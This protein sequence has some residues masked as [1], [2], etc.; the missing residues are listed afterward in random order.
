L[1]GVSGGWVTRCDHVRFPS[2]LPTAVGRRR[3]RTEPRGDLRERRGGVPVPGPV[4]LVPHQYL[5]GF[6]VAILAAGIA[7]TEQEGNVGALLF[8]LGVAAAGIS[9]L[10]VR[11]QHDYYRAARGARHRAAKKPSRSSCA[12]SAAPAGVQDGAMQ[13]LACERVQVDEIWAFVGDRR[14]VHPVAVGG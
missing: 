10:I 8:T 4:Q 7:L 11:P 2:A 5:L 9:A 13:D 6:N 14:E 12:T 1:I 3:R